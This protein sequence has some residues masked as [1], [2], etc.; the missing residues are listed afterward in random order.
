MKALLIAEKPS[1]MKE[2]NDVYRNI[3]HPDQIKFM[4]FAGHV[5]GLKNPRDYGVVDGV[6]WSNKRWNPDMI[7]MIPDEF[8]YQVAPDKK[9]MFK[10][11]MQEANS[12]QYD[13]IINACDPDREG[14]HIFELFYR[15]SKCTLPVKRFWTNDLS[16][17]KI[18]E[19][20]MN[21]R[22]DNDGL[23][24]NLKC[25]T[26][27]A[28]LRAWS[29][30]LFGM[31]FT[32][33]VSLNMGTTVKIGRVKT[34][35]HMMLAKRE[36]EIKN[37][38]PKTT[39]EL[40]TLYKEGFSGTLFDQDGNVRFEKE[41]DADKIL[42]DLGKTA[43]VQSVETKKETTNAPQL[44]KLSDLQT[45][46]S[47]Y[48]GYNA[49]K[50]LATAQSLYEKKVLS[51]PRTDCRYL[52]TEQTKE[53]KTLLASIAT[54]PELEPYVK[55]LTKTEYD[56]VAKNKKYVNDAELAKSG[57]YALSPTSVKPNWNSLTTEEKNILTLVYK[58]FLAIFLPPMVSNKTTVITNNNDYTFKTTGKQLLDKGYT[59]IYGTST[60]D[61]LLP[62]LK[63]GQVV[64]VDKFELK[65]KTTTCPPRYTQG[66]LIAA[67]ENPAKFL[68]DESLKDIIKEKQGIGTPATRSDIIKSLI[69]D[70]YVEEK[71]GK[72]KA[73]LL[74]VTNVGMLIYE[75]LKGEEFASVDMTG[76][77]EEKLS[78]VAEG[79]LAFNKY[80]EELRKYVRDTTAHIKDLKL[81]K[82]Q[83]AYKVDPSKI[84]G[85][86]PNC[87]ADFL[88]GEKAYYCSDRNCGTSISKEIL[89]A[90]IN[91]T[92]AKKLIAGKETKELLFTQ[93]DGTE[94]M[95]KLKYQNN[96]LVFNSGNKKKEITGLDC[97]ICGKGITDTGKFFICE[98]YKNPCQF[99]LSHEFSGATFTIEDIDK[100][101]NGE[102]VKKTFTWKNGGT[103]EKEV[104]LIEKNGRWGYNIIF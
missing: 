22:D 23:K 60:T 56:K 61:N 86:C 7:P 55:D 36:E 59:I 21:L 62:K 47:K 9:S 92:E 33:G 31:N 34:A 63:K 95:S 104:E 69:N 83:K 78:K 45:D 11:L 102:R 1:L 38:K 46:G 17:A 84:I 67:M 18:E 24:P 70:N 4:S 3:N 2:I 89:G 82:Y 93:K 32:I 79:Q 48:F 76:I 97:P 27:A 64:N 20:L 29:D 80:N 71:K 37:F 8:L 96:K 98:D 90:K 100:M 88:E 65:A 73:S 15:Q 12:G 28:I 77:W 72:G 68:E 43:V 40:D 94:F 103:G 42:K 25:L 5:V 74:Y 87:E 54:L 44:Y 35:T 10:S 50:V 58:R 39:Y 13:Y 99:C 16:F 66:T 14:N 26:D 91:K 51:Y 6:D 57:H 101:L 49:D 53:F 30:W 19:A 85:A 52:G 75:N 41:K 81:K